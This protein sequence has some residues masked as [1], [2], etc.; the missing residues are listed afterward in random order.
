MVDQHVSPGSVA[1]DRE[2]RASVD[3]INK[4]LG[5]IK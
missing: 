3:Q 1:V 2:K 5:S 4:P